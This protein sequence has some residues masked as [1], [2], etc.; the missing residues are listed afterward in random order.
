MKYLPYSCSRIYCFVTSR[1]NHAPKS[2]SF[3]ITE[4][5]SNNHG[6]KILRLIATLSHKGRVASRDRFLTVDVYRSGSLPKFYI[7]V[8]GY[9]EIFAFR[10]FT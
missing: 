10:M 6:N 8:S 2:V 3:H 1:S 4:I 9:V 5:G 7:E